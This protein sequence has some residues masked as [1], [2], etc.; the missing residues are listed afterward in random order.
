MLTCFWWYEDQG[1]HQKNV[2]IGLG[3]DTTALLEKLFKEL[4]I[5]CV[6]KLIDISA[7]VF[8]VNK[9]LVESKIFSGPSTFKCIKGVQLLAIRR[10][11]FLSIRITLLEIFPSRHRFKIFCKGSF[12]LNHRFAMILVYT[13]LQVGAVRYGTKGAALRFA[14]FNANSGKV[15]AMGC[16]SLAT[17]E[18]YNSRI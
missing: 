17:L 10:A 18:L 12:L 2:A 14:S 1:R 8:V 15:R 3:L 11:R 7:Y 4:K 16:A 6:S 5:P 13:Y 9:V